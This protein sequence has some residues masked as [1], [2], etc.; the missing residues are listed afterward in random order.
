MTST[1]RGGVGK[2]VYKQVVA[3]Y[4]WV[5]VRT[6]LQKTLFIIMTTKVVVMMTTT[7]F[8]DNDHHQDICKYTCFSYIGLDLIVNTWTDLCPSDP[9]DDLMRERLY[10]DKDGVLPGVV[11]C[12]WSPLGAVGTTGAATLTTTQSLRVSQDISVVCHVGFINAWDTG[13]M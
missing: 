13:V 6:E 4:G 1:R 8:I 12:G 2:R 10:R 7:Y 5:L 9:T 11:L 3:W